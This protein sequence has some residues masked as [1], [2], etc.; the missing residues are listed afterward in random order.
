MKH[1]ISLCVIALISLCLVPVHGQDRGAPSTVEQLVRSAI[2]RM[3]GGDI[4]GALAD[5]EAARRMDP[6]DYGIYYEMGYAHILDQNYKQ[7]SKYFRLATKQTVT[8]GQCWQ[9]LGNTYDYM[10]KP[11]KAMKTYKQGVEQ[12][13]EYG[14][15]YV[16]L[17]VMSAKNNDFDAAIE[18]WER[19]VEAAPRYVGNYQRLTTTFASSKQPLWALFYGEILRHLETES[20][21]SLAIGAITYEVYKDNISLETYGAD[22]SVIKTTLHKSIIDIQV[23]VKGNDADEEAQMLQ[24]LLS[25]AMIPKFPMEVET[26]LSLAALE[27]LGDGGEM[28]VSK[29]ANI[30]SAFIQAWYENEKEKTHPNILFKY[31]K[32][33]DDAGHM[34][35]YTHW[36]FQANDEGE[37][38]DWKRQNE[39]KYEAFTR[40]FGKYKI[41]PKSERIFLREAQQ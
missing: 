27:G 34:E 11:K 22:S 23:S 3:D 35:A 30:R 38:K 13:P 29:L 31:W 39:A 4:E 17:G 20:K 32:K 28:T 41:R 24:S 14:G 10:G 16:E 37:F 21:R 26:F 9:M 5:L 2:K 33:V 12:F 6:D 19:G 36:L 40:W 8:T 25:A 15:L 1:L 18:Y 7:A